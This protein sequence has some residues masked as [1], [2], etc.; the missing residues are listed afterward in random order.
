MEIGFCK[1]NSTTFS[2]FL[3]HEG[4]ACLGVAKEADG[5]ATFRPA[6]GGEHDQQLGPSHRGVACRGRIIP[7]RVAELRSG[8]LPGWIHDVQG[9]KSLQSGPLKSQASKQRFSRWGWLS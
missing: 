9:E 1:L 4:P 3:V 5:A 6:F 2:I 8:G 7:P